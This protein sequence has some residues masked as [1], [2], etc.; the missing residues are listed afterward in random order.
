M[1]RLAVGTFEL[2]IPAEEAIGY[3]TPEGERSWV[4]GWDPTYPAGEATEATGTVFITSHD[5]TET[6]WVIDHIDR[7]AHTAAYVRLTPGRHAGTVRVRC[8]DQSGDGCLVSVDYDLTALSPDQ[9]AA[10]APYDEEPFQDMLR[11]WRD[12]LGDRG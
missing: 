12:A 9:E 1:R 3:F 5:G 8:V 6:V 11:H 10:L 4:P 2:P 7:Q